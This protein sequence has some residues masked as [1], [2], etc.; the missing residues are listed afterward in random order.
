MQVQKSRFE[1]NA[2]KN[3]R[4]NKSDE[5]KSENLLKIL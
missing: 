2:F 5:N 4:T 1:K 3:I